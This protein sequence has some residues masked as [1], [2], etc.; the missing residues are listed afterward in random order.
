[1][2]VLQVSFFYALAVRPSPV[3]TR[4]ANHQYED[5]DGLVTKEITKKGVV[6]SVR[7]QQGDGESSGVGSPPRSIL[8][9]PVIAGRGGQGDKAQ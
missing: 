1:M 9:G 5:K 8:K 2:Q 7:R 6:G 4:Q 3:L